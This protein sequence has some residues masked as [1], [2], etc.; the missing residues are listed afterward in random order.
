[1]RLVTCSVLFLGVGTALTQAASLEPKEASDTVTIQADNQVG[2][3]CGGNL[4][5]FDRLVVK[6]G[7]TVEPFTLPP[8]KVLVVTS[9]DWTASGGV[10]LA[11]RSR[12][13]WLFRFKGGGVN[14]PSAQS[15]ALAEFQWEGWSVR[16]IPDR[17]RSGKSGSALPT[18]GYT[19]L[20]RGDYR[21]RKRLFGTRQMSHVDP[22][23]LITRDS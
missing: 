2:G 14:G 3:S 8:Q 4:I 13:A 9:F 20:W 12:T 10:G 6:S 1:M 11:N 21:G 16:S 17:N 19:S 23:D 22:Y 5:K 18:D 15:T 7:G